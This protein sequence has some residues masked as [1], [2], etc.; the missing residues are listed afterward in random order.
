MSFHKSKSLYDGVVAEFVVMDLLQ[1]NAMVLEKGM[2]IT[3]CVQLSNAPSYPQSSKHYDL[4]LKILDCNTWEVTDTKSIEVKYAWNTKYPT[5]FAEI[6]QVN[7]GWYAEYLVHPPEYMFYVNGYDKTLYCYD[8][9]IFTDKVKSEY[10]NK[11]MNSFGSAEGVLFGIKSKEYGY[12]YSYPVKQNY[13][14]VL[15]HKEKQIKH[16]LA[17]SKGVYVNGSKTCQGLPNLA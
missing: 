10:K 15:K 17:A 11:R 6:I 5:F 1:H 8:G 7:S 13:Y 3:D 4:D 14:S 9:K 12:L 2:G 16:R